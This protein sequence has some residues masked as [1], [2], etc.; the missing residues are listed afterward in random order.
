MKTFIISLVILALIIA[1]GVFYGKVL[2]G[3]KDEIVAQAEKVYDAIYQKDIERAYVETENLRQL[4]ERKK[5]LLSAFVD[6][7]HLDLVDTSM[8]ELEQGLFCEEFA[9]AALGSAKV[10]M[11]M[12]DIAQNERVKLANIL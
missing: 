2:E 6:H 7:A 1:G 11:Q 9:D 12:E 10:K 5:R 8:Q 3:V 4:W